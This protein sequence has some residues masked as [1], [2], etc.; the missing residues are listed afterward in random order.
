VLLGQQDCARPH[1]LVYYFSHDF[2]G[3]LILLSCIPRL[4]KEEDRTRG[5][6][7]KTT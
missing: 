3:L 7:T 6:S 5:R 4:C 2:S 1:L